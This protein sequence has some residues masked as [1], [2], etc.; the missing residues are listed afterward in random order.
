ML[1]PVKLEN[2]PYVIGQARK[3]IELCLEHCPLPHTYE[4]II[5]ALLQDNGKKL[6]LMVDN[7]T[8]KGMLILDV[9]KDLNT[10]VMNIYMMAHD[11]DYPHEDTDFEAVLAL[12]KSLGVNH[13]LH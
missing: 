3:Y 11:P 8:V 10:D 5:S 4:D 13:I 2:L 9:Y 12:A 1:Y 7:R 6:F